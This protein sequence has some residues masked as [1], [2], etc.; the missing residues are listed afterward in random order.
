MSIG[1]VT[2]Y[3]SLKGTIAMDSKTH[4]IPEKLLQHRLGINKDE[5]RALRKAHLKEGD[6]WILHGKRIHLSA[7]GM[8]LIVAA[9]E[10][11]KNGASVPSANQ[12]LH[13]AL[14]ST[15]TEESHFRVVKNDI[16]NRYLIMAC[17]ADQDH[18]RPKNLVRVKIRNST[19]GPDKRLNLIRGMEIPARLVQR[20]DLYELSR[21]MP[22][23]RGK[24]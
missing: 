5:I 9:V 2:F 12:Q 1:K 23:K 7:Q 18:F 16:P 14:K 6:H 4:P 22:R 11:E 13:D 3:G 8:E 10:G 19:S 24:W 20:P 17:P 21:P 15:T